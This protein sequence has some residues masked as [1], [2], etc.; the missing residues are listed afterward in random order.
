MAISLYLIPVTLGDTPV[1]DV[2]PES[3]LKAIQML[4]AFIVENVRSARRFLRKAG[5]TND[6]DKVTFF[7]MGKHSD[8]N[9]LLVAVSDELKIRSV[10]LLSE[11]G[12]PCIADPGALIASF[13][14]ENSIPVIPLVGPSSILL[15]LM[16]SGFNGQSFA[17]NGYL[18][19]E[20][21]DLKQKFKQMEMAIQRENQTQIFI[22]TPFRNNKLFDLIVSN[23][24]PHLKL[25]IASQLTT[26]GQSIITRSISEWKNR[27]S[28]FN[29]KPAVF[30]LYK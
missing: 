6:F 26:S 2:L 28:D 17:F 13:C 5:Y 16:A 27:K 11:A 25:C 4:D 29:K 3:V 22:E 10:G 24:A 9:Q 19:I 23:V 30:L 15:A 8:L 21:S 12:T 14:H 7:E 20:K 18:P 1:A